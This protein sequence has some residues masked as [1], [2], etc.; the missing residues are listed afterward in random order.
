MIRQNNYVRLLLNHSDH[1]CDQ[2]TFLTRG[3][4]SDQVSEGTDPT[5]VGYDLPQRQDGHL[6]LPETVVLSAPR[7]PRDAHPHPVRVQVDSVQVR[8]VALVVPTVR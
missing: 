8:L 1:I 6:G 7:L 2:V 3:V 4:V 5:C